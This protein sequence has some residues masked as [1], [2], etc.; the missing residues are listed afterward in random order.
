MTTLRFQLTLLSFMLIASQGLAE[1]LFYRGTCTATFWDADRFR[2]VKTGVY[3]VIDTDSEM[4]AEIRVEPRYF[5]VE[6]FRGVKTTI[7][8]DR[9]NPKFVVFLMSTL[10]DSTFGDTLNVFHFR[11]RVNKAVLLNW[12]SV[13]TG[14]RE[15]ISENS[16]APLLNPKGYY[17]FTEY[18]MRNLDATFFPFHSTNLDSFRHAVE[19][20]YDFVSA[21]RN[22]FGDSLPWERGTLP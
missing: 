20:V 8:P 21:H 6:T 13:L 2:A 7:M 3:Y 11:G 10:T 9:F 12:P 14:R 19:D 4:A 16:S 22:G 18:N 15:Y 17:A 5:W 1:V